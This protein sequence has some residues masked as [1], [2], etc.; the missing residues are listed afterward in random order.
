[1]PGNTLEVLAMRTGNVENLPDQRDS[2]RRRGRL[3]IARFV[4]G[5]PIGTT[6]EGGHH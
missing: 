2:E 5:T 6:Q 3:P 4:V 1:M